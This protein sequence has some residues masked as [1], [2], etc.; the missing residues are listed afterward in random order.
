VPCCPA[1]QLH[2]KEDNKTTRQQDKQLEKKAEKKLTIVTLLPCFF[3]FLTR[4]S[5]R[6][7]YTFNIAD[8]PA[9]SKTAYSSGPNS[10]GT[11]LDVSHDFNGDGFHD[12]LIC[13]KGVNQA[14]LFF[15]GVSGASTT[16]SVVFSAPANR[17]F[18]TG[19]RYAGDV[20]QDGFADIIFG[21]PGFAS[22]P[23]TAFFSFWWCNHNFSFCGSGQ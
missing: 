20:N 2:A 23:G 22:G 6:S 13:S 7:G 10:F 5:I 4:L 19:C 17:Q 8:L 16:P 1:L 14:Y 18:S 9:Y 21:A 3:L 12:I 11:E 15:G